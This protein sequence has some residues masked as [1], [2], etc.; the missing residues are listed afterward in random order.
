MMKNVFVSYGLLSS[1]KE[2][3]LTHNCST[4]KDSLG[5]PIL[6]L[7]TNKVIGIHYGDSNSN[8]G[9]LLIKSLIEFNKVIGNNYIVIKKEKENNNSDALVMNKNIPE[10]NN[11]NNNE[12][13]KNIEKEQNEINPIF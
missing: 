3:K 8:F 1:I 7:K 2:D 12:N 9:T 10:S 4:N 5:F 6:L 11:I 13:S